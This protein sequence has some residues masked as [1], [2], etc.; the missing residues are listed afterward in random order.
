M[1]QT[2]APVLLKK[3]AEALSKRTGK[4]YKSKLE[5][6]AGYRTPSVLVKTALIRLLE[7]FFREPILLILSL[8]MGLGKSCISNIELSPTNQRKL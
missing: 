6:E 8:Y 1:P 5:I 2:Y 3:R 7:L 4:V